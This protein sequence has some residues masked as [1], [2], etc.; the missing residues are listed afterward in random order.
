MSKI[1]PSSTD[2]NFIQAFNII[3]KERKGHIKK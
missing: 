3:D 1:P 2:L